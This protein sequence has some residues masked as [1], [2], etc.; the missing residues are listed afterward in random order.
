MKTSIKYFAGEKPYMLIKA[1]KKKMLTIE[2][3]DSKLLASI[4]IFGLPPFTR[5]GQ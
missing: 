1:K 5:L 2:N 3:I 4:N